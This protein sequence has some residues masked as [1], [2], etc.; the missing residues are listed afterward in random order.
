MQMHFALR[1]RFVGFI[2][3]RGSAVLMLL[4]TS[5]IVMVSASPIAF[6]QGS[7]H[8]HWVND[9]NNIATP[10]FV[11]DTP[12]AGFDPQ[13][14]SDAELEQWGFPPRPSNSDPKAYARWKK[15]ASATRVT[16]QFTFT[17]IYS[18]SA[19]NMKLGSVINNAT[20]ATSDNWSGY[21]ITEPSGTFAQDLSDVQGQWTVPAVAPAPG[22]S[23]SSATYESLQWVGFDGWGS[24]DVLQA[25][26]AANCGNSDYAFYEWYPYAETKVS[27]S[28]IPGDSIQADVWYTT[29]SPYGHAQLLNDITD[30]TETFGFNPPSGTTYVGNS[31]EWVMERPM[32]TVGGALADLPNYGYS[33]LSGSA[34]YCTGGTIC[35]PSSA[36]AGATIYQV[37]MTCPPWT[38]SSACTGTTTISYSFLLG[39]NTFEVY[40]EP[41]AR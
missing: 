17:K 3:L 5:G 28:V 30:Q 16:P 21:V 9:P 41:P 38:P 33:Y 11:Y 8:G 24:A 36:P 26:T 15:M 35:G 1:R 34:G 25:G 4:V 19:R 37:D 14:A 29:S 27:L 39:A 22:L 12:P 2:Q 40:T 7:A 31:A 32:I 13:M 23:C 20:A 18:G 6:A 10:G